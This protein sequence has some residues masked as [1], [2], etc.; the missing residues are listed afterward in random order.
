MNITRN[1]MQDAHSHHQRASSQGPRQP[2]GE[3]DGQGT[4]MACPGIRQPGVD[5]KVTEW[6]FNIGTLLLSPV[7]VPK[8]CDGPVRSRPSSHQLVRH[9]GTIDVVRCES[10]SCCRQEAAVQDRGCRMAVCPSIRLP[11][12]EVR[13]DINHADSNQPC[14]TRA[15]D[16]HSPVLQWP[17]RTRARLESVKCSET[18]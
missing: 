5:C 10:A 15:V 7:L 8:S 18:R 17:W 4:A 3:V 9:V 1:C 14:C 13:R 11:A 16:P 12:G 2:V 6:G